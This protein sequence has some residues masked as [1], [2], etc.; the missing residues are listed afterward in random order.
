M[1]LK[2]FGVA[3]LVA[4]LAALVPA[5]AA[6]GHGRSHGG[7][8]DG[9]DADLEGVIESLPASGLI[10]DW[11][12]AGTTVHVT[13]STEI[14]QDDGV[15]AVGATVEVEGTADANGSITAEK[16]EVKEANDDDE[17]GQIEFEGIVQTLPATTGFIGDWVVS[18]LKVHVTTATE[19]E[20][21]DGPVAVGAAVEVK[22][23]LESDGS[24][25]ANKV[26]VKDAADDSVT[27]SGVVQHIPNGLV[28]TWRVSKQ[29]VHVTKGTAIVRHGHKLNRGA[30]VAVKGTWLKNGSFRAAKV[31]VRG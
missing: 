9:E 17:F 14:E 21:E 15:V 12:V 4:M 20:Q 5:S 11:V 26:E 27:L 6:L 3:L 28:G 13:A 29:R 18:G 30:S 23:L 7:D 25:T 22:G 10:G 2:I 19:I 1:R 8:G 31:V 16:I 24:V